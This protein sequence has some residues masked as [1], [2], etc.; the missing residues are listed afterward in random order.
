MERRFFFAILLSFV[1]LY[2][3]QALFVP[4]TPQ[5]P[6][7]VTTP[8]SSSSSAPAS[9]LSASATTNTPAAAQP[10]PEAAPAEGETAEREIVVDTTTVQAVLSNR[11]GR[12]LHWRLKAFRDQSGN[13]VD[14]VDQFLNRP[15]VRGSRRG[16]VCL[17]HRIAQRQ[18]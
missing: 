3:Y 1:V 14:L 10:T 17:R 16:R 5:K 7:T 11:G 9:P 6:Q 13:L 2:G 15:L 8:A 4:P 12:V 18:R